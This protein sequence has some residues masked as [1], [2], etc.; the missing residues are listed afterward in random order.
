MPSSAERPCAFARCIPAEGLAEPG[1]AEDQ[2]QGPDGLRCRER[3]A[4]RQ[5]IEAPQGS[6]DRRQGGHETVAC[7]AAN[8]ELG[9]KL[10]DALKAQDLEP[11][12]VRGLDD[13]AARFR[14]SGGTQVD[15]AR[16][17]V[18]VTQ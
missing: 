12:P 2:V 5:G 1:Q 17:A 6:D 11:L 16:L 3:Q 8:R 18:E 15:D 14:D 13:V 4:E 10:P 7:L 9:L